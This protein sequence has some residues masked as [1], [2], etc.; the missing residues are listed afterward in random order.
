MHLKKYLDE[1]S[2]YKWLSL[3]VIVGCCILYDWAYF[4][5]LGLK[6]HDVPTSISEYAK[7]ILEWV[8]LFVLIMTVVFIE[9]LIIN[10]EKQHSY[11]ELLKHLKKYNLNIFYIIYNKVLAYIL[12]IPILLWL[13]GINLYILSDPIFISLTTISSIYLMQKM[14]IGKSLER[15]DNRLIIAINVGLF[16]LLLGYIS[17][18]E[19]LISAQQ[20]H[21]INII[22]LDNGDIMYCV[23]NL[24]KGFIAW[25]STDSTVTFIPWYNI[26]SIQYKFE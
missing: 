6:F 22:K 24:D 10:I 8:P 11:K 20:D 15:L 25:N 16:F 12:I 2:K 1:A 7:T 13:L 19:D 18:T 23:R 5:R 17:A 26:S 3:I 21:K 4:H 14:F 9:F